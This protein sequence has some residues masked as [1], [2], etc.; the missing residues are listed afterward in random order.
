M[1]GAPPRRGG[2]RDMQARDHSSDMDHMPPRMRGRGGRG[3]MTRGGPKIEIQCVEVPTICVVI[4]EAAEAEELMGKEEVK[5]G[6]EALKRIKTPS[7]LRCTRDPG[8]G[9]T[10][11]QTS[12]K[13]KDD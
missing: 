13:V 8:E 3:G 10:Q 11:T 4:E 1:R 6:A 9:K 7:S 2:H 12:E 5:E